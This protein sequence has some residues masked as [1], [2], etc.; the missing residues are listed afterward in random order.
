MD[1][2]L[3]KT[4]GLNLIELFLLKLFKKKAISYRIRQK[5]KKVKEFLICPYLLTLYPDFFI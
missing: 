2:Q 5:V 3:I 4:I 1:S